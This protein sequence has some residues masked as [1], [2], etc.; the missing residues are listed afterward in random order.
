MIVQNI[1]SEKI[2]QQ[3]RFKVK[4]SETNK[5]SN[6]SEPQLLAKEKILKIWNQNSIVLFEG[7]TSSGKTEVY[8]HLINRFL[9]KDFKFCL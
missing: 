6:L 8:S 4:F 9:K 2:V 1:L 5:L 7:V 3:D